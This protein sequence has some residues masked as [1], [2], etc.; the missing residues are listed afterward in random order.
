MTSIFCYT[1][2]L[3]NIATS[4]AN[5]RAE[6]L[7]CQSDREIRRGSLWD[8]V[9]TSTVAALLQSLTR[10][11]GYAIVDV[12]NDDKESKAVKAATVS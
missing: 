11:T 2:V 9:T 8:T 7:N 3:L 5:S 10:Q 12:D 1:E 4:Y 6:I